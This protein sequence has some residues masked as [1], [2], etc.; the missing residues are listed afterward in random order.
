MLMLLPWL[1]LSL[2][3]L[4]LLLVLRLLKRKRRDRMDRGNVISELAAGSLPPY[5]NLVLAILL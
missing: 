2:W 3:R 4:L 5:S 1:L